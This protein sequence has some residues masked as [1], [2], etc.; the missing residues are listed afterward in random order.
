MLRISLRS[1]AVIAVILL[2]SACNKSTKVM[3]EWD[4]GRDNIDKRERVAV[5]AMMPE[6]LQRLTIEQALVRVMRQSGRNAL[7]SSDLPGL[8]GRLAR[9]TAEPALEVPEFLEPYVG[10]ESAFCYKIVGKL[11]P[12][13][14][15]D[16]R[17]L[18]YG[19]VGERARV[20]ENGLTFDGLHE[21]R[22]DGAS[23]QRCHGS[24][25]LEIRRRDRAA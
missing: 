12:D 22:V 6:A 11:E 14:V 21:V 24:V 15:G 19:D 23:H 1:L 20:Y 7:V 9:E 5:V 18:A 25:D 3:S 16:N 8:S 2:L 17:R 4:A 13:P 10:P